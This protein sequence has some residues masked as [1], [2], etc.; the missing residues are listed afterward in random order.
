MVKLTPKSN[1][2][3]LEEWEE[4]ERKLIA[5]GLSRYQAHLRISKEYKVSRDCIYYWLSSETHRQERRHYQLNYKRS[6]PD[7]EKV[8]KYD[9]NYNKLVRHLDWYLFQVLNGQIVI[10]DAIS[11]NIKKITGVSI[12][13][14]TIERLVER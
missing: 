2:G 6:L 5:E 10:I 1:P 12:S 11:E 3:I 13:G 4:K 7:P 8:K 9:R 14:D